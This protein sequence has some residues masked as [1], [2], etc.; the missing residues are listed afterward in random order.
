MKK[1]S[2][3]KGDEAIDLFADIVEPLG[4]IF[5]DKEIQELA[6]KKAKPIEYIK[7]ALKNKKAELYQVMARLEGMEVEE[8]KKTVNG[9]TFPAQVLTLVNDP[10]I[11]SLFTSQSQT[12]ITSLASSGSATESIEAKES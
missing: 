8:Y 10:T 9:L 7:P 11:R 6:K 5:A 4:R 12:E 1:L 3:Y 2:D